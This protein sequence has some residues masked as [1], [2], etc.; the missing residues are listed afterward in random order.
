[1]K[2][3]V[4]AGISQRI[5]EEAKGYL[6]R[7]LEKDANVETP[8]LWS[9]FL[10]DTTKHLH[11]SQS[12][13]EVAPNSKTG[14]L[15]CLTQFDE[16]HP[17]FLEN[18]KPCLDYF[19]SKYDQRTNDYLQRTNNPLTKRMLQAKINDYRVSLAGHIS[20][21]EA[22]L[23]DGKRHHLAIEAIQK[24]KNA[25]YDNPQFY[26]SHL[27]DVAVAI[28]SLSLLPQERDQMLINAKHDL[29]FAAAQATLKHSP[30]AILNP[31]I[32]AEWKEDLSFEQ[33]VKLEHQA[34]NLL[35]HQQLLRQHQLSSLINADLHSILNTGERVEG[36]ENILQAS[37]N[38]GDPRLLQFRSQEALYKQAFVI[39]QQIKHLPFTQGQEIL[40]QIAPKGGDSD[41]DKKEKLYHILTE[42]FNKQLKLAQTD[43]AR[44]AEENGEIPKDIPLLQRLLL[45]KQLQQ[46]KGIPS[47]DQRYLM[48]KERDEYL[49]KIETKDVN[50]IQQAIDS[51]ISLRDDEGG[52]NQ[53]GLEILDEILR[54]KE[55]IEC[56]TQFYAENRLYDRKT[57]SA[58]IQMIALVNELSLKS[59]PLFIGHEMTE[60]NQEINKNAIIKQWSKDLAKVDIQN[61]TEINQT[62]QA[63]KYLAKYYQHTEDLDIDK[64][65][66][67]ATTKLISEVDMRLD[68]KNLQIPRQIIVRGMIENLNADWVESSLT[69]LQHGLINGTITYDYGATFLVK[70]S[71]G[72]DPI[73]QYAAIAM[74]RECLQQGRWN[75]TSDKKSVYYS[76]PT[77]DGQYLP[78]LTKDGKM[79]KFDLLELNNPKALEQ[80]KQRLL[81]TIS[82]YPQYD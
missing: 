35:H 41:Y 48:N 39:S 4:I 71:G 63:I 28:N 26:T 81:Q 58:F 78:V 70:D 13:I 20:S 80:Q 37:F 72:N 43:P 29:A 12:N 40:Q 53:Y 6:I 50:Q 75:L 38:A 31:N 73:G 8:H 21:A 23:I 2:W 30:D 69:E 15:T 11:Q 5:N 16:M 9:D 1:M 79:L 17:D 64:A 27:Q 45:R 36:I 76:F 42:Q 57:A 77:K 47:Y 62:R 7:K 54:G 49:K 25:T 19:L 56:L 22:K 46:Q 3:Q 44:L 32:V 67:K 52:S 24:L 14:G 33:R 34:N 60:F 66:K 51:I 74:A 65:V 61:E 10:N 68:S 59:Q 18:N 82:E 55:D